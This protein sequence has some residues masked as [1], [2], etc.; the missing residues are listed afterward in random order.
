MLC[1]DAL[2]FSWLT[3][4]LI[5]FPPAS[6]VRLAS[7]WHAR[8]SS[9]VMPLRG[10]AAAVPARASST[11]TTLPSRITVVHLI[12]QPLVT[13]ITRRCAVQR[14]QI[15]GQPAVRP[16]TSERDWN[17]ASHVCRACARRLRAATKTG[18]P[19]GRP[20]GRISGAGC[21]E[22]VPQRHRAHVRV[23]AVRRRRAGCDVILAIA[24]VVPQRFR[25][26]VLG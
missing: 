3:S 7:A 15:T 14:S 20:G 10:P 24:P 5:C 12:A 25:R 19:E 6:L 23:E 22:G 4:R 1:A 8:H 9:L 11:S 17:H 16:L 13:W 2:N 18:R 21:L 26:Q